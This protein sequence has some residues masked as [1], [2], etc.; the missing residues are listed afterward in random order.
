MASVFLPFKRNVLINEE[1]I[2]KNTKTA[3]TTTNKLTQ[4]QLSGCMQSER[5]TNVCYPVPK[6]FS[7]RM[8][9]LIS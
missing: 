5:E 8:R 3:T 2:P 6:A 7:T 9:A 1:T 4:E